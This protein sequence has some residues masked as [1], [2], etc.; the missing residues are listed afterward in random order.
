[1]PHGDAAAIEAACAGTSTEFPTRTCTAEEAAVFLS[2]A[3][4]DDRFQAVLTLD[5]G[6]RG[7]F[8]DTGHASMNGPVMAMRKPDDGGS[9]QAEFDRMTGLDY[10]WVSVDGACHES[11]NLGIEVATMGPCETLDPQ[12][13]WDIT[14]T[15]ALAFLRRHLL[16]DDGEALTAI[17]DGSTEVDAAVTL[18]QR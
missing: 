16:A 12:R 6:I 1:V 4:V 5:G 8:G 7:L 14:A 17:L 11:F 2:G 9:D 3:L 18:Q 15:Y 10:T 13:G